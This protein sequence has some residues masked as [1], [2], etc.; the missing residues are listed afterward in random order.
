LRLALRGKFVERLVHGEQLL[1]V[2]RGGKFRRL[3][4]NALLP[5]PVTQRALATSVLN[6][7]T[8]HRLCRGR[9]EMRAPGE[10]RVVVANQP[11]PGLVHQRRRLECIACGF[12]RH[13]GGGKLAQLLVNQR[14]QFF[15][16]LGVA[17][18][19]CLNHPGNVAHVPRIPK[20]RAKLRGFSSFGSVVV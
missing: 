10:L 15:G 1:V 18:L 3:K 2:A 8:A 17:V 5:A 7:D 11:Q 20:E 12:V 6:Q 19:N 4:I 16:G 13:L 14:Q 9:K